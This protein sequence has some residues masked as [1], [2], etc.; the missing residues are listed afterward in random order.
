MPPTLS[1]SV[2]AL[3][4]A[5]LAA[6]AALLLAAPLHAQS[7]AGSLAAPLAQ[8]ARRN[9]K[10][11][12]VK[13]SINPRLV[14]MLRA[15]IEDVD[16]ERHPAGAVLLIDSGGGD[17]L[18]AM[19]IGR[20]ARAARAHIFVRGRCVSACMFVLAGGVV[21]GNAPERSVGIHR[22][23]LTTF[24]KGIGVVDINTATN[25]KA[26]QMLEDTNRLAESYLREMGMPDT[27]YKAMMA[28]PSDQTKFLDE[29]ELAA[30]GLSGF[31]ARYLADRAP[32]AA[33]RYKTPEAEFVRRTM[34]VQANCVAGYTTGQEFI[35]CYRRTL[36]DGD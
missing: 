3:R 35:R 21:R 11:I 34:L 27:L 29:S 2:P 20:M 25:A 14:E 30:L 7:P 32:A 17:G 8:P 5:G 9:I 33:I 12:E 36:R 31:D 22:P 16:P 4:R 24:V 19:E 15:S 18:A 28:V 1:R 26:A 13:G 23:R 6:L 10:V